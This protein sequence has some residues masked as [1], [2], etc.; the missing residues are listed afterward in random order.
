LV[1][2]AVDLYHLR[3]FL[4]SAQPEVLESLDLE[5]DSPTRRGFL[6]RLQGEVTK[7][8]VIDILRNGIKHGPHTIDLFYGTP[9]PDNPKAVERYEANRFSITRQ[10]RYSRDE[11]QLAL[12]LCLFI[13]GLPFATFELKNSLTKQTVDDAVQQYR[14]DRDPRELLFQFGRCTVHFAVDDAEVRM[15]T[16]L[17]GKASWFLPFNKGYKNGAGN[18]PNPN[19]LKT[20]YLLKEVLEPQSLTNIL[21]NYAQIVEKRDEKT[22]KKRREQIFPPR[23]DLPP[24]PPARCRAQ[25]LGRCSRARGGQA[26]LDPTFG[27]KWEVEFDRLAGASADRSAQGRTG[28]VRFDHRGDRSHHP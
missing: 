14:R 8:G 23:A 18:P 4:A 12:D 17:K 5:N 28:C 15:C 11:T 25:A 21:E 1:F 9:S 16:H 3:E 7:R 13:N 20:D 19:G 24:L 2:H 22:G 10:L 27:G 26:L 6:A